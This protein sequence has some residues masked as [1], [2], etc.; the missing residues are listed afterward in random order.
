MLK[1]FALIAAAL[2][3]AGSVS[4]AE[5]CKGGHGGGHANKAERMFKRADL[6]GDG[7]ISTSESAER[8]TKRFARLDTNGD[9]YLNRKNS[10][11]QERRQKRF[12]KLDTDQ[13]GTI[14]KAEWDAKSSGR[15]SKM[16]TNGD[17]YITKDEIEA[18]RKAWKEKKKQKHDA[19]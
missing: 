7:K 14:S 1:Q 4:V 13:N 8:H 3:V 17:G 12:A 5:A 10:H 16:D 11:R 18:H 6:N 19:K 9:E 2:A 15:F